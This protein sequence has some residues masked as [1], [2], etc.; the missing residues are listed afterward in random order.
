MKTYT[1]EKVI[2]LIILFDQEWR[3]TA[4]SYTDSPNIDKWIEENL[5]DPN[6]SWDDEE[7]YDP[8][9]AV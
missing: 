7:E 8:R 4:L 9:D 6:P 5:S 2:A 1:K 3:E